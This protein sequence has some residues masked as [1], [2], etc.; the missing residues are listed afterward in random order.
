MAQTGFPIIIVVEPPGACGEV[1]QLTGAVVIA[2]Q[3]GTLGDRMAAAMRALFERGAAAVAL[4]GSDLPDVDARVVADAFAALD[5]EPSALVLGPALDGGYYLV[6]ATRP[7]AVFDAIDWGTPQVLGQ[8][9]AAAARARRPVRLV[10]AMGDVDT[11]R[12]LRRVRAPRTRA[13]VAAHL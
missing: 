6:A 2:Q 10:A 11:P 3:A 5:A 8:T 7:A 4:I 1:Q 12:D 9:L 13:W